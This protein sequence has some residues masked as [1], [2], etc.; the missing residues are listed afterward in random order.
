MLSNLL[1]S[2]PGLTSVGELRYLW[3]R[4]IGEHALCGC[5]APVPRCPFWS[6]VLRSAYAGNP[7]D[8]AVIKTADRRFLRLRTFPELLRAHGD[9]HRLG[10]PAPA[11]A[12]D[13]ARLYR[14]LDAHGAGIVV[15]ASKL[16]SYGYLLRHVEGIDVYVVHLVRDPRG[17]AHSWNRRRPRSDRG[18]GADRMSR[19]GPAKSA[20]LWDV[21][22][23]AAEWCWRDT[24]NR[25]VRVRYE[26]FVVDP[27]AAL[28][29]VLDLLGVR[30]D[31]PVR[32]D[33]RVDIAT[34][35]T[36]AGNPNRM[37]AGITRLAADD[38]WRTAMPRGR[39]LL[40]TGLTAPLLGH[41]GYSLAARTALTAGRVFVE[42][43]TGMRRLYSR[44]VRNVGWI[45]D[46]GLGRVLEE[47]EIDPV[48]TVP[49]A[50]RKW[51]YR[52]TSPVPPGTARPIFVV[53][54]QR[55][56]TNMLLRG[57]GN[58][59][60]VEVHNENDRRAFE[61]YKLRSLATVADIVTGSRHPYVLFKPLCDSHRTDELLALP[62]PTP[63]RAV[64]AYRDVD[65]RVR[66]ALA[67]FGDGNLQ[68]LR[69]FAAGVNTT[70][71]H[72]QRISPESAAF[73]RSFAYDTMTPE[74]GAALMWL[75]RNRLFFELHLDRR[76]DV[77]LVSYQAFLV[78]PTATMQTLCGFLGLPYTP[79]LVSHVAARPPTH[80]RPLD[81][82]PRIRA[83]CEELAARLDAAAA[84]A[85]PA[86]LIP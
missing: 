25:Y 30:G 10:P 44:V 1:G 52:R 59:P 50:A 68:V 67:K 9:P 39:R 64:W 45:R 2:M 62:T 49:V 34:S 58:A 41:Y 40:V 71:W 6:A 86:A 12:A 14:A 61:R 13:L 3:E 26:D 76:P 36:V 8:L 27:A 53:G 35:H 63:P 70:R 5:G 17:V 51:R 48:R 46:Q 77:H 82:D 73:V 22:N 7:P 56:G 80:L 83:A 55:S 66:S 24:P 16:V 23:A 21:W 33:G 32:P 74:S 65:G 69:E 57:L 11:Y 72:V 43:Q 19:E 85:T 75:I 78:D 38:E 20:V 54:I 31:V 42:D 37:A 47:Q 79:Q 60:E 29:P 18:A 84:R 81:I 28:Q 15:D 4:G